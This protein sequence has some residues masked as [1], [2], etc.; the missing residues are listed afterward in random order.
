MWADKT[1]IVE[2]EIKIGRSIHDSWKA[3]G[4]R[5]FKNLFQKWARE[6]ALCVV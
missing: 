6:W 5:V 1:R 3:R 4:G 2:G